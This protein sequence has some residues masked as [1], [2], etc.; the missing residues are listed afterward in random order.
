MK[1]Q[2]TIDLSE[3]ENLKEIKESVINKEDVVY[4]DNLHCEFNSFIKVYSKDKKVKELYNSNEELEGII[5]QIQQDSIKNELRNT[6]E[7]IALIRKYDN[8]SLFG[9]IRWWFRN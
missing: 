3:Y 4:T 8:M 1:P 5:L 2:V 9:I 6:N 7:R